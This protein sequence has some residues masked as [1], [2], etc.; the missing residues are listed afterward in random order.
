MVLLSSEHAFLTFPNRAAQNM[1]W[2]L[3]VLQHI[4]TLGM[5]PA[6]KICLENES[7]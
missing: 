3:R 7:L 2:Y 4:P 1:A 5:I 6:R